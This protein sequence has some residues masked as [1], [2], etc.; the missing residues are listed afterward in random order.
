MARQTWRWAKIHGIP[1][2][3]CLGEGINRLKT[4]KEEPEA[5]NEDIKIPSTIR[6]LGRVTEAKACYNE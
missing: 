6:W 2:A 4:L 3:R 5:D 1:V